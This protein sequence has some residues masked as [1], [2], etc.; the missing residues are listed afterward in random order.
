MR[1][2]DYYPIFLDLAGRKAVVVGGGEVAERKARGLR[3]TGATVAVVSPSLTDGLAAMAGSSEIRVEK[4]E[5][6]PGD[7]AGAVVAIAATDDPEVNRRVATDG[8]ARGV[9]VN[10]VDDAGHSGFIL[11]SVAR[12]GDVVVAIS[13][14]GRSPA[15]ARKL[16]T[17]FQKYLD[18]EMG[19][20]AVLL[21][22]VRDEL[23]KQGKRADG[24]AWQTCLDLPGLQA[25]VKEGKTAEARDELITLLGARNAPQ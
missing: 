3:E 21:S 13:T 5:Y 19:E 7:L 1:S 10:V 4:R 9:L 20:I 24:E 17:E 22:E 18:Q 23:K 6:R 14:S 16:R 12:R 2:K 11:P 8:A 15:L 25:K